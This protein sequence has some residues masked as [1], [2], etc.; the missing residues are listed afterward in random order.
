MKNQSRQIVYVEV[1]EEVAS[2]FNRIKSI[3]KKDIFLV[4][5]R[6]AILFQSVVNL[7]ILK[8]KL[9]DKKKNLVI[10]TTD[11]NGK[12]IAEK[13]G[14][15]T[16]SRIEVE[17]T[18]VPSENVDI[19]IKPIQARRN[20]TSKEESPKRFTEK[21]MSIREL[22]NKFRIQDSKNKNASKDSLNYFHFIRPSRKFL[23]L[24]V[25]ISISLFM[26]IGYIALPSATINIRPKFDNIDFTMNI[27]LADKRRN[28]KFLS[29]NHPNVIASET[30]NTT[31]KQ[32]KIFN[33]TG[34]EFNGQNAKGKI[35][36]INT[37]ADK[38][39]L[40]T[41]T[42]FQTKEGII[43]RLSYGVVVP[44]STKDASGKTTNGI[45][46]ASVEADPFDKYGAPVG[47]NGNI[48]PSKFT[49]PGLS[50]YNQKLIWG[51]SRE[52]MKGGVTDYKSKITKENI[53]AAKKQIQS[54]LVLMAR[55]DLKNYIG[56]MN[57]A[58]KTNLI[59]LNN[60]K[61]LKTKLIDLKMSDGL[62]GSYKDKF[63]IFAQISAE[64]IAFDSSQ[65]FTLL[66]KELNVRTHPNMQIKAGS[67][68]P[69]NVTYEVIDQD[70]DTGQIKITAEILGIEEFIIDSSSP[71]GVR[72]GTKV[73]EKILGLSI[74][75][76]ENLIGNF[77]EVDVVKINTWPFW[78]KK[79]PRVPEGLKIKLMQ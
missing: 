25:F 50:G 64:G 23:I 53:D 40:K 37:N 42:R 20:L 33:T 35:A 26:L 73:K 3:K 76:A 15:T 58:N 24:I 34:R 14:I 5:P 45:L 31:I 56:Q 19:K 9:K 54:N 43:F 70:D 62:E 75:E 7:K 72:F 30:V 51:E 57:K 47:S 77:S 46:I 59:L 27:V 4:V 65:L 8:S 41:K 48:S 29:Q 55:D 10:V 44:G 12:H 18:Q 2:I 52:S 61:Y 60:N 16:L 17:K 79:I 13:I 22:I 66:K 74:K 71:A 6:K 67:I 69:K 36:I 49:I 1:D 32:T 21:K 38:W 63:E 11:R 78:V 39:T 68:S 28:Q